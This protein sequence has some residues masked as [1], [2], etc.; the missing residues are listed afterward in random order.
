[1]TRDLT[2]ADMSSTNRNCM[3]AIS[4]L[5]LFP[6]IAIFK[7]HSNKEQYVDSYQI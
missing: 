2:A 3:N 7:A 5:P 6:K 1:M 4:A